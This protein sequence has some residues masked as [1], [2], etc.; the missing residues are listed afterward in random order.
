MEPCGYSL[1]QYSFIEPVV[2]Y[3]VHNY[4][5]SI[6]SK[7]QKTAVLKNEVRKVNLLLSEMFLISV[8][9]LC[10]FCFPRFFF[11]LFLFFF[12]RP[13]LYGR[14]ITD[15]ALN[16][17]QSINQLTLLGEG[18]SF[19]MSDNPSIFFQKNKILKLNFH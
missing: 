18:A 13:P 14:N 5:Y 2:S 8:S 4:D 19:V 10:F 6:L 17:I 12:G 1:I 9:L 11:H 16:S 7:F 15:T 3:L